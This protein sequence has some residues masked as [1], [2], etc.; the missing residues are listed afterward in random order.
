MEPRDETVTWEDVLTSRPDLDQEEAFYITERRGVTFALS[1]TELI[2]R[3]EQYIFRDPKDIEMADLLRKAIASSKRELRDC[4]FPVELRARADRW[5][6]VMLVTGGFRI[7]GGNSEGRKL[8]Q[9]HYE[10]RVIQGDGS[11]RGLRGGYI[12]TWS[13]SDE[14]LFGDGIWVT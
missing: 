14:S 11:V 7:T 1:V 5:F 8:V 6:D 4:E 2:K 12:L 13:E 10:Y 3:L 9:R